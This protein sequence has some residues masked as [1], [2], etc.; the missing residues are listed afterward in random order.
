MRSLFLKS[1]NDCYAFF[2]KNTMKAAG[3]TVSVVKQ[4]TLLVSR[5]WGNGGTVGS[6]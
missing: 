1:K 2:F 4:D 5:W 3:E 6:V